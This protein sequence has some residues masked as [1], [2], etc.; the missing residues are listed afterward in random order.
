VNGDTPDAPE[1][2]DSPESAAEADRLTVIRLAVF[3]EGGL[4]LLASLLGWLLDE[5]PL[6]GFGW[7]YKAVLQG[8]AATLPLLG[9]FLVM[10][11]WPVGPLARIHR[12]GEHVIR[13]LLAPCSVLDLLGISVLAGLGEEVLF[14]GVLQG[15]FGR[16]LGPAAGLAVAS[17]LFGLLHA[18]T[19][20]YVVLAALMGA[21][22]GWLWMYT[23]NLLAPVVTHA[24][25]DFAVLLWLLR[26]PGARA[27][28]AEPPDSADR[29]AS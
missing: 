20:T 18:V 28:P 15:Y 1:P 22:L 19:R 13:P 2:P 9:L 17:G 5:S 10:V 4:L 6:G 7:D 27:E 11:R 29:P 12:F 21:Y 3:V 16:L 23:G 25:Y 24:L 14:R 26:R 8:A